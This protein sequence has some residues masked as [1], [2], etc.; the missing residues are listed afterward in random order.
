MFS[1]FNLKQI[2]GKPCCAAEVRGSSAYPELM[3][4]VSFFNVCGGSVVLA[5][6]CGLP[7]S[8]N[9]FAMHIHSGTCAGNESDPFADAGAHL[10]LKG[11]DHP[12]H[13]GDLPPL[14]SNNGYAWYAVYTSRFKPWNVKGCSVI[15]HA[16]PDDFMTQPSGNAGEKIACG[17]IF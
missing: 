15:I 4:R 9:I 6:V 14:F 7:A 11:K 8:C 17:R 16:H 10:N 13:T 3:G 1:K 2:S 5:E 12:F